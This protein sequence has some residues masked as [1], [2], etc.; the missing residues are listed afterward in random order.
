MI[1]EGLPLWWTVEWRDRLRLHGVLDNRSLDRR[2]S[3]Q[4]QHAQL[5]GSPVQ[6]AHL[7]K[8]LK[9][10]KQMV[11][12]RDDFRGPL[13]GRHIAVKTLPLAPVLPDQGAFLDQ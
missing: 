10:R 4:R 11:Q 9:R 5:L 1:N 3:R 13:Q 8:R 7:R 12:N 6:F 2:Q